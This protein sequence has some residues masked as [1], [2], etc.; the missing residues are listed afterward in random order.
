[1]LFSIGQSLVLVRIT[2]T[3]QLVPGELLPIV[4]LDCRM[5]LGIFFAVSLQYYMIAC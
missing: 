3:R 5:S 4:L 1:M 2:R